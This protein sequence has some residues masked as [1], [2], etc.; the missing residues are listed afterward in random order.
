MSLYEYPVWK[1]MHMM[2]E[3]LALKPGAEITR[4]EVIT[5]FS[6]K[7]PKIKTS[8]VTAHLTRMSTNAASRPYYHAKPGDDDLFYKVDSKTF[9]LYDPKEDPLPIYEL[10]PDKV[11]SRKSS[12]S[13]RK[14][15]ATTIITFHV[16][17]G[18]LRD[19]ID[20][21]KYSPNDT[22]IRE[23]CVILEDRLKKLSQSKNAPFGRRLVD[24]ILDPQEGVLV[25]SDHPNEQ[26]GVR[27]LFSGVFQFI[28]NPS[29]HNLI[30]YSDNATRIFIQMIDSLL[31]ILTELDPR[32]RGDATLREATAM[33]KMEDI[34][35]SQQ[36]LFEIFI[37]LPD[38]WLSIEELSMALKASRSQVAQVIGSIGKRVNRTPGLEDRGATRLVFDKKK[39]SGETYYRMKSVFLQALEKLDA[40]S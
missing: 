32:H 5:Y 30:E 24:E 23:A 13:H 3:D 18:Q 2:V 19:R 14:V 10:S 8:T 26:D 25:F 33:L 21:V 31:Q 35:A 27:M 9:R 15:E 39:E 28:R 37:A 40:Q 20:K 7:Y 4:D 1:L 38:T 36:A 12:K 34:T 22:I 6:R 17:D 16:Y 11:S 29:M